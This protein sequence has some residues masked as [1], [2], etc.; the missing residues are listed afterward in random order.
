METGSLTVIV[1]SWAMVLLLFI[2]HHLLDLLWSSSSS[3]TAL[4]NGWSPLAQGFDNLIFV[5]LSTA[6]ALEIGAV[7]VFCI[8]AYQNSDRRSDAVKGESSRQD[9]WTDTE[10]KMYLSLGAIAVVFAR[11]ILSNLNVNKGG[12]MWDGAA[13][14][15]GW[16]MFHLMYA[17]GWILLAVNAKIDK[18]TDED[19]MAW[20][21]GGM[22][23]GGSLLATAMHYGK[24]SSRYTHPMGE[25]GN[26]TG[27]TIH[28]AGA[29]LL[30]VAN[31]S[32]P[33][34]A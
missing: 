17:G 28:L 20:F 22:L 18:G 4:A 16:V 31:M 13:R 25:F 3:R 1:L 14:P 5:H 30:A 33:E 15:M 6:V 10:V 23:G 24:V 19:Y 29:A 34:S 32:K 12:D 21:G 7:V 26:Y 11:A 9:G 8:A 2:G 27:R